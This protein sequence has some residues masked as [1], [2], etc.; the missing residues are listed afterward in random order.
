V[1]GS[2][3]ISYCS[4]EDYTNMVYVDDLSGEGASLVSS[5]TRLVI[6]GPDQTQEVVLNANE[7]NEESKR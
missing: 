2:E 4:T 3:T 5:Q 6:I 7:G 1:N